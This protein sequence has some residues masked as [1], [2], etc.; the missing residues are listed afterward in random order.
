MAIADDLLRPEAL[1]GG[2]PIEF[3]K[4]LEHGPDVGQL[5]AP[6]SVSKTLATDSPAGTPLSNQ[7][8]GK[9]ATT[10]ARP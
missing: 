4:S 8:P 7:L 10:C 2:N 5:C 6:L 1:R 9:T 3:R